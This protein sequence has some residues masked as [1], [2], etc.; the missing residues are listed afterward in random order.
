[1]YSVIF[2]E[3]EKKQWEFVACKI[4]SYRQAKIIQDA[5]AEDYKLRGY[6]NTSM[7]AILDEDEE[8]IDQINDY[9]VNDYDT[10]EYIPEYGGTWDELRGEGPSDI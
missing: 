8:D 2:K 5:L 3:S 9:E 4:P 1:M 7:I 10:T 6:D